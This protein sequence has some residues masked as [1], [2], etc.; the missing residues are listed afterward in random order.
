MHNITVDTYKAPAA[1]VAP[2]PV[3][4]WIDPSNSCNLKCGCCYT[5]H[6]HGRTHLAP[7]LFRDILHWLEP[8][9]PAIRVMH[10]NW[11]GEPLMNPHFERL[12]S[13]Y[14]GGWESIPLHWHTNGLLLTRRRAGSLVAASPPHRM[15]VSIDGGTE[16][17]HDANRGAGTFRR[18]LAGLRN[19]LDVN[20]E[21]GPLSVGLYQ[22]DFGVPHGSY[23][24]EFLELAG[25]AREWVRVPAVL[26]D[27]SEGDDSVPHQGACFWAGYALCI[28]PTGEVSVCVLAR[29]RLGSLGNIRDDSV[30]EVIR[31][32]SAWRDTL[33]SQGRGA[34][35][36]CSG[37][38]KKDGVPHEAAMA[39]LAQ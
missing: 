3:W 39:R 25:R 14:G 28:D 9:R 31:R 29:G 17:T 7:G 4:L 20:G 33:A 8:V 34:K 26:A 21:T 35:L 18:S 19:L 1:P 12:L 32:A 37:C 23:D 6:S 10:L 2:L 30:L 27:G 22:I 13:I 5:K 15:F 16:A 11:R 36:Q 24:P 38:K